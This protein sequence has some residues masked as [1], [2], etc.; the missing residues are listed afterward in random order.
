MSMN[1]ATEFSKTNAKYD[2]D[3]SHIEEAQLSGLDADGE[4]DQWSRIKAS[5]DEGE[6]HEHSLSIWQSVKIY[7]SVRRLP[8]AFDACPG[9]L[10]TDR[11]RPSFGRVLPRSQSFPKAVTRPSVSRTLERVRDCEAKLTSKHQ[12]G[13]STRSSN[14]GAGS[15]YI[16]PPSTITRCQRHGNLRSVSVERLGTSSEFRL[17][18]F[19]ST[20]WATAKRYSSITF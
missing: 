16:T 20:A 6:A 17:A 4:K 9:L 10:L 12:T 7:K 2:G 3:I 18:R 14:T 15:G 19:S 13:R 1:P 5:A 11:D 8:L